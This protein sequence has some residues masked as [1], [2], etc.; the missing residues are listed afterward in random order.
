MGHGVEYLPNPRILLLDRIE[1]DAN[2]FRLT[3]HVEQEPTC[4]RCGAV[5][6]SEHSLCRVNYFC[7]RLASLETVTEFLALNVR[8]CLS[9][10][11]RGSAFG[12]RQRSVAGLED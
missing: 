8:R 9:I 3:V 10:L 2:R 7:R 5:S 12:A 4:P 1:R 11:A 6:R